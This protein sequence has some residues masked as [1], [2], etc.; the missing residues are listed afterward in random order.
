MI[1]PVES[2]LSEL[3]RIIV[4]IFL[5][6]NDHG[7]NPETTAADVDGWDSLTHTQV[8]LATERAF[9]ITIS[10]KEA[11]AVQTLGELAQLVHHCQE[12]LP[13]YLRG[14]R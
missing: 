11:F 2:I 6:D 4:D 10:A 1:T 14:G 5:L 9:R 7:L 12:R 3:R 8:I 13:E